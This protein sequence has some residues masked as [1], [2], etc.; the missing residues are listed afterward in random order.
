MG[1]MVLGNFYNIRMGPCWLC[2][3]QIMSGKHNMDQLLFNEKG[4]F[5]KFMQC[6]VQKKVGE[7][8]K[9]EKDNHS[10]LSACNRK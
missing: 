8:G 7:G 5:G 6:L 1:S 3:S 4:C 10:P 9:N 2:P